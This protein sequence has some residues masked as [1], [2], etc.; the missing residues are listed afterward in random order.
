MK[1]S[2]SRK[3]LVIGLVF[4]FLGASAVI[5]VSAKGPWTEN[6]DSYA[7]G[8]AL[9]G[10]GGW[11]GWDD[12]ATVTGYVSNAQSRSSPNS[13]EIAWFSGNSADMVHEYNDI[14]S[15]IWTYTAYQYVPSAM[16]GNTF[17]ILMNTYVTGVHNSPDWSLQLVS[18]A[19][20]GDIHDYDDTA[21][22]LPLVTDAWAKIQVVIDLVTDWQTITYN[23]VQLQAKGWTDG[24][25][26]GGALNLACVDL[27]ADQAASTSVYW[28]DMSVLPPGGTLTCSANGP[29]FGDVDEEIQF[30]GT[31]YE[32]TPPYTTWEWTFG[33]GDTATTQNA[34]HAYTAAGVYNVTLTVT[35][36][37][38]ATA[39][40]ETTATITAPQQPVIEIGTI[41][42][43]LFKVKAVVKNPGTGAA[44]N[45]AWSIN[46]AG[47]IILLGKATTGTIPTLAAG[48][49]AT[50]TSK[51]I[52][53]FGKT[54]ITVT[55]G[56]A[57]KSQ[58]ATVLLVFI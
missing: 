38:S 29:Y 40:D 18:S 56:T 42:G 16:T 53:G 20:A 11:H 1:K 17:F 25:S 21:A 54:V 34:T 37:L 8:S 22:S 7:A 23:D 3:I 41:T 12:V 10:Q 57:T 33:D 32:G 13:L 50:I 39:S 36:S 46:L 30:T 19:T 24:V 6:F 31:A 26:P 43:G 35:D 44:T 58:N 14:N 49:T 52:V 47:G 5:G 4:L 48:G 9:H 15:G 45:V 55:A 2:C 27:Y 51:M 28:D